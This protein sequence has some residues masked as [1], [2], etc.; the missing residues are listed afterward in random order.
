MIK[1][2]LLIGLA[3]LLPGLVTAQEWADVGGFP[4]GDTWTTYMHGIAVD[5]AGKVWVGPWPTYFW[6]DASGDSV[7][8]ANG[9]PMRTRTIHVYNPDGT[10]AMEPIRSITVD[11]VTDTLLS[12]VTIRGLRADHNG[13]IILV[14]GGTSTMYRINH[15]TGDGMNKVVLDMGS[16]VAPGID[17]MGNI[18]IAPVVPGGHPIKVYDADFNDTG[19]IVADTS[20]GFSRSMEVSA[21]GNTVYWTG[22]SLRSIIKY[23]RPDEFSPYGAMPDTLHPGIIS[24]SNVRHPVTG[25][26]WFGHSEGAGVPILDNVALGYGFGSPDQLLSWYELDAATDMLVDS[27]K[28]SL[29]NPWNLQKTR[30]VAFAPDG[31]TAYVSLWETNPPTPLDPPEIA[32]KKFVRGATSIERDPVEIPQG[33]TLSQNYP[34]PFN[35]QTRIEFELEDAGLAKLSVYDLLGREVATLVDEHLSAGRYT[36]TF[37]ATNLTTGTYIYQLKVAGQQLTGKMLLVK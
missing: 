18:Y 24:E 20:R 12:S 17:A 5:A 29:F 15:Q 6:V 19:V 32:V 31:N 25:N 21:D 2:T 3:L 23:T 9:E 35:P 13:D 26:V 28:V 8:D 7:R 10:V 16:P 11:G 36:A 30:G 33:F 22:Y 27:F 4:D 37:T 14:L 1:K 34:N